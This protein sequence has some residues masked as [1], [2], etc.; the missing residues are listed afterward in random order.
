MNTT[1]NGCGPAGGGDAGA[2]I[3]DFW[4]EGEE[5]IVPVENESWGGIKAMY[6]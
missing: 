3:D 2:M 5:Y 4:F 6:R 1:D